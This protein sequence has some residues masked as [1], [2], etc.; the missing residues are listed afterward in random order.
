MA[1]VT[2]PVGLGG[3]GSTVTDDA[4]A[5]TGLANGGHRTRFVPALAQTVI[6]AQ[7]AVTNAGNAAASASAASSSAASAAAAGETYF[8]AN[9]PTGTRMLFQQTAAPTGWTKETGATYNDA[10]LRIVTGSVVNGGADAFSTLFGTSKTTASFTLTTS[11]MPS[12]SHTG[13]T[14]SGGAHTHTFSGNTG[15]ESADHAHTY[16]FKNGG[17]VAGTYAGG[18]LD[19]AAQGVNSGGV[20]A[21]HYHGFS[22]TTDGVSAN[23]SHT[24]TAEGGGTGHSHTLNSMNLKFVD[25]IIA[26]K[27]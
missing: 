6:M 24:I 22:G 8:R 25:L 9:I 15:T 12:H 1:S 17:V 10:A 13:S 14:S 2:F 26:S 18:A 27:N 5:S 23:H 16:S 11:H 19:L 4:N 20:T 7:T 21:N 3:N